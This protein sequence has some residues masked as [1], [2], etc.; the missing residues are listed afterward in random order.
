MPPLILED[1][2]PRALTAEAD[3]AGPGG[4]QAWAASLGASVPHDLVAGFANALHT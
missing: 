2:D 3:E 1:A 4:W